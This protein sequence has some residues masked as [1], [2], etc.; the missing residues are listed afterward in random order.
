[1]EEAAAAAA[2]AAEVADDEV[3]VGG[4]EAAVMVV[5]GA[6]MALKSVANMVPL[7]AEA[8]EVVEEV[9]EA[10]AGRY[11]YR[12]AARCPDVIIVNVDCDEGGS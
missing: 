10:L 11:R 3:A 2:A 12:P 5:N 9:E 7:S 8:N 6:L 4:A 1:M